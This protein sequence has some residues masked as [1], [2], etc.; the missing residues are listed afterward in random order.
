MLRTLILFI[1][2]ILL[3]LGAIW[4]DSHISMIEFSFMDR[5][6]ALHPLLMIFII[7]FAYLVLGFIINILSSFMHL[8][9]IIT[10]IFAAK[11]IQN[12]K[13]L[14]EL[15]LAVKNCDIKSAEKMLKKLNCAYDDQAI[16]DMFQAEIYELKGEEKEALKIYNRYTGHARI[17]KYSIFKIATLNFYQG[18]L[19]IAYENFKTLISKSNSKEILRFFVITGLKLNKHNEVISVLE[20]KQAAQT[21]GSETMNRILSYIYSQRSVIAY[22]K[23]VY[24]DALE[25]SHIA[26]EIRP[27]FISADMEIL[28]ALK[29]NEIKRA[30]KLLA[31]YFHLIDPA[32]LYSFISAINQHEAPKSVYAF[33]KNLSDS[34]NANAM[35]VLAK[36]AIDCAQYDQ[37]NQY[38]AAALDNEIGIANL[39]MTEY[40]LRTHGNAS[41]AFMWFER[42]T[43]QTDYISAAEF[44]Q[45]QQTIYNIL[46]NS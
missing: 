34:K 11:K 26:N 19:E 41:E 44:E 12:A 24:N 38:I 43:R 6:I 30:M 36:C 5:D 27:D 40:C 2:F 39:L 31:K 14:N 23:G 9:V 20:T 4:L 1:F 10:S 29:L 17:E 25:L 33:F 8:P 42:F 45:V 13:P 32:K 18:N 37:A 46:Y 21:F 16:K 7:I 22:Q 28:S 3:V 35:I 15:L